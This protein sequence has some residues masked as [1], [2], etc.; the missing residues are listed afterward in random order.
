[1]SLPVNEARSLMIQQQLRPGLVLDTQVLDTLASIPREAFVPA[2]YQGVAFADEPIPLPC[3]QSMLTP[4]LEGQ[5]LQALAIRP[6][7]R[8][9]EIGTGSGY[10]AACL[11]YLGADVTTVEIFPE[12][13]DAARARLKEIGIANCEVVV[14]DAFAMDAYPADVIAVTGSLSG[15]TQRFAGWLNRGGRLFQVVGDS[16]PMQAWRIER[17]AEDEYRRERL[18]ETSLPP[19]LNAPDTPRFSF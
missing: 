12:L 5:M 17:V 18:F 16:L 13:A 9:L 7:D 15:N 3:R 4:L 19:L 2:A 6:R 11:A 1:M 14:G 8:I 10:V